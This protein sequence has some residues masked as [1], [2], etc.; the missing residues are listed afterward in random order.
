V[1]K[2][3]TRRF[4]KAIVLQQLFSEFQSFKNDSVPGS[5]WT[6]KRFTAVSPKLVVP[7][8]L[9]LEFQSF[10]NDSGVP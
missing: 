2:R 3:F 6:A 5:R 9:L 4:T 1:V 8:H 7:Q 10:K